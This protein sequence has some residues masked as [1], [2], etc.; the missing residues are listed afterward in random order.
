[1]ALKLVIGDW[2]SCLISPQISRRTPGR[3]FK[4]VG[5]DK[6][7]T[8]GLRWAGVFPKKTSQAVNSVVPFRRSSCHVT[9]LSNIYYIHLTNCVCVCVLAPDEDVLYLLDRES[10]HCLPSLCLRNPFCFHGCVGH[11]SD[12]LGGHEVRSHFL[13]QQLWS[14]DLMSFSCR[15]TDCRPH[16]TAWIT[17]NQPCLLLGVG[18]W[19]KTQFPTDLSTG[20]SWHLSLWVFLKFWTVWRI[21]CWPKTTYV[22]SRHAWGRQKN[23][24][25]T[26]FLLCFSTRSIS[27]CSSASFEF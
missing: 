6:L 11:M 5:T 25:V 15:Q 14:F 27:S 17:T 2:M 8:E 7:S 16:T 24:T 10:K 21:Y 26:E 20:P 9:P 23:L 13:C 18:R 22:D 12:K 1:M 3:H 4:A 19:T